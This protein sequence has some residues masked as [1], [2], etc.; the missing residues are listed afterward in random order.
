MTM[1][2]TTKIFI[3][4]I[5][6][7][8]LL[9][10]GYI[11]YLSALENENRAID[12]NLNSE[13]MTFIDIP[14][15]KQVHIH[16]MG[17]VNGKSVNLMGTIK[18]H[19]R[20]AGKNQMQ[21]NRKLARYIKI[22]QVDDVIMI[23]FDGRTVVDMFSQSR[24]DQFSIGGTVISLPVDSSGIKIVSYMKGLGVEVEGK[25]LDK[26]DIE[27]CSGGI[28]LKNNKIDSLSTR[29]SQDADAEYSHD[30]HRYSNPDYIFGNNKIK[31]FDI[32]MSFNNST[33]KASGDNH[34]GH[35]R[36]TGN[37]FS[38]YG[39]AIPYISCDTLSWD[40]KGDNRWRSMILSGKATLV[41]VK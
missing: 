26:L 32:D 5:V 6:L 24:F 22:R 13:E 9:L 1:K 30:G 31:K 36:I 18:L 3:A 17:L 27:L 29:V 25:E 11:G 15:G 20:G 16:R 35:L 12:Y 4:F 21:I 40:F 33:F 23:N 2:Q 10:G 8:F 38:N 39:G 41:N 14:V 28:S 7:L 37:D 34:I 19:D